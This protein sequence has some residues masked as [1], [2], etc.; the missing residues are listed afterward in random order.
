MQR[1]VCHVP[2]VVAEKGTEM[3]V[4]QQS[5]GTP[6]VSV[7]IVC[8][9]QPERLFACLDSLFAR[10]GRVP[11]EVWVVAYRFT[12]ENLD[13]LR[14]N[15]PSVNIVESNEVRGFS[16]NN[17]LAL[18]RARGEFCLCINDDT[19]MDMPVVDL[20]VESFEKQPDAAI[21]MPKILNWDGTVQFCGGV[22]LTIGYWLAKAFHLIRREDIR[23]PWVNQPGIF[24]TRNI[25]G[26][27]FMIRTA[28]LRELGY[29]DERYF[30]TPEDTALSTLANERGYACYVNADVEI[31]HKGS[32]TLK[33]HYLPVMLAMQR[34]NQLFFAQRG[35][36]Q[37]AAITLMWAVRDALTFA[38]WCFRRGESARLH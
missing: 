23:S 30:F 28:V 18:R 4:T 2:G 26:A 15:Y 34:G 32:T 10:N 16:E 7:V 17:N 31:F 1:E 6:V 38:Y 8:M 33:A 3:A 20:L 21:F 27:A 24:R 13:S 11:F 12:P 25:L 29:L 35:R 36:L 9:N 5:R 19:R 37:G 14:G 22:E